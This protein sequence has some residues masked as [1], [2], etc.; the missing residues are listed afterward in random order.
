MKSMILDTENL[1]WKC[2]CSVVKVG[3]K[4]APELLDS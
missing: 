2:L 3:T 1:V 4:A